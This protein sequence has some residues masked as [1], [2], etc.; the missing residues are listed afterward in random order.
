MD[1][2][3]VRRHPG[4]PDTL[5]CG[6]HQSDGDPTIDVSAHPCVGC[7]HFFVRRLAIFFSMAVASTPSSPLEETIKEKKCQCILRQAFRYIFLFAL[8]TSCRHFSGV[9]AEWYLAS[10]FT[11]RM[12]WTLSV[13]FCQ[14]SRI[15]SSTFCS[16]AYSVVVSDGTVVDLFL[17]RF[18]FGLFTEQPAKM[19]GSSR[20]WEGVKDF[21]ARSATLSRRSFGRAVRRPPR[22]KQQ[23]KTYCWS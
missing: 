17:V 6:P 20:T 1:P 5:V 18:A 13:P 3:F 15:R 9:F 7:R 2:N 12:S 16:V 21:L 19:R 11:M 14:R 10:V 23:N 22:W 8:S 4:P